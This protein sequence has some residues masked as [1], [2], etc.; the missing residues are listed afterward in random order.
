MVDAPTLKAMIAEELGRA[1]DPRL[2]EGVQP[3]LV[4]PRVVMRDWDYGEPGQQFPCWSVLE[5]PTSGTGMA[6]CEQGFGS[7][8]GETAPVGSADEA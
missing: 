4:E 7:A 5:D 2:A 6:Y 1:G 8:I 3:L